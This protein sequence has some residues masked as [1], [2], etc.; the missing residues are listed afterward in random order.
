MDF[1]VNQAHLNLA[2]RVN[3]EHCIKLAKIMLHV[4]IV[5]CFCFTIDYGALYGLVLL[6]NFP[7]MQR[8]HVDF[9]AVFNQGPVM[10]FTIAL[11][12]ICLREIPILKKK[13]RKML[14]RLLKMSAI[15]PM[16]IATIKNQNLV[17]QP[18]GDLRLDSLTRQWD[19]AFPSKPKQTK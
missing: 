2:S 18:E 9:E 3:L 8:H 19:A 10:I 15:G 7:A 14:I 16:D 6:Q 17:K 1:C 13:S 11:P 4:A 5:H 12:I